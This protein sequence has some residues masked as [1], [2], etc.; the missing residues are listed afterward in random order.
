MR[1]STLALAALALLGAAKPDAPPAG[2]DTLLGEFRAM[3]GLQAKFREEKRIAL[4]AAPLVSE[5]TL[6]FAPPAQLAR[7]TTSPAPSRL[8]VDGSSLVFGDEQGAE[9]IDLDANPMARLYV[10]SFLEILAGNRDALEK[11]WKIELAPGSTLD[12]WTL[13]LTPGAAPIARIFRALTLKGRGSVVEW[14]KLVET[15]GD[16]TLTTFSD[17]DAKHRYSDAELAR[18]FRK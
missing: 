12:A 3:P 5:G 8:V 18:L 11:V 1:R 14:L 7:L 10:D 9:S 17:V 16:E 6:H 4:L 13:V 2:V 15:S